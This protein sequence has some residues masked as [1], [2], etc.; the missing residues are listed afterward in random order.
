MAMMRKAGM[1][2]AGAVLAGALFWALWPQP[3]LVDLAAVTRAP[4]Q[5]VITAQGVTRVRDPYAITAPFS[6]MAIRSPVEIGDRVVAGETV[7][8]VIRPADPA[9]LDARS[10]T[11]AE[12]AVTEAQAAVALAESNLGQAETALAH[13][14]QELQRSRTL[15]EKDSIPRHMLEDAEAARLLA[16][17]A[18][19]AARSQ[20][21][22]SHASLARAQAQLIGPEALAGRTDDPDA[23][24]VN[25]LSPQ[26][27]IVLDVAEQSARLVQAG[28]PLLTIGNLDDLEIELDL[29]STDAVRV[30][31]DARALIERWGGEGTLEA[32]LRRIEPAAFTRVSALGIEEQRVRLRLDLL[33]KPADRPGLGDG[34]RVQVRLIVWE[35]DAVVQ[36]PQAALFRQ[37]DGWAVFVEAD[38]VARLRPVGIGRQTAEQA[39]VLDGLTEGDRVVMYP[40]SAMA[41]GSAIRPRSN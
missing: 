31:A 35:A 16:E 14:E 20:L 34:F 9:L 4:M 25:I 19:A 41:D 36:V 24:C 37:G 40:D 28:A 21:D 18:A 1:A 3:V 23:C 10:R 26:T 39:E 8:A 27:G 22:L 29:L 13:A 17:Q 33:A 2:V 11:Q 32:R 38:G 6:G 30:P 15:A 12:A 7:V 5:G